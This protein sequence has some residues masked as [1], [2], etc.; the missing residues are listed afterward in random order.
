MGMMARGLF[1]AMILSVWL[2][3]SARAETYRWTD[4]AGVVHFSDN[5]DRIP[6]RYQKKATIEK[7][8]SSVNI[9]PADNAPERTTPGPDA[10]AQPRQETGPAKIK[11]S[12]NKTPKKHAKKGHR[13]SK[14]VVNTP[15]VDVTPARRA[16]NEAEEKIRKDRQAIDN[17]QLP[18]RRAQ[19][20]AEEQIKK[21]RDGMAGH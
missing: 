9:M 6:S 11:S 7:D 3:G 15:S 19:D 8:M 14:Q 10:A 13:K 1:V 20:Q 17:A 12:R 18:A 5:H 21:T 16:Q 2:V 4:D